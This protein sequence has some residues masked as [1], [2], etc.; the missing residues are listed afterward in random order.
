[1]SNINKGLDSARTIAALI[2]TGFVKLSK[3]KL[4]KGRK[5]PDYDGLAEA[6]GR[7]ALRYHSSRIQPKGMTA[8]GIAH[9]N[10]RL[11]AS[12]RRTAWSTTVD[13][14]QQELQSIEA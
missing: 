13:A 10:Q 14:V 4:V 8:D 12:G 6:I 7:N 11:D 5:D 3:G 1:M 9:F 2:S